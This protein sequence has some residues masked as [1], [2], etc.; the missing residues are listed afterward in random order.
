M[1]IYC[2]KYEMFKKYNNIKIKRKIDGKMNLYS[3]FIDCGFKNCETTNEGKI[4]DLLK[5]VWPNYKTMFT[6]LLKVLK[7]TNSKNPKVVK[8]KNRRTI[9]LSNYVVC[10]SKITRF[11]K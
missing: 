5:E 1:N 9:L 7:I 3:R 2:I 8:K 6:L 4:I 10:N 11:I